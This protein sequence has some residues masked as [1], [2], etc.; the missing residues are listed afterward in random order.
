M[1][2]IVLLSDLKYDKVINLPLLKIEYIPSSIDLTQY[3][4][5]I[6]TSKNAIYSIDSF[7]QEWKNI[8]SYCIAPKTA[9][10]VEAYA[11]KIAF[12]GKSSHGNSFA[13]ELIPILTSKR[14]LY[15]CAQKTV[16]SLVEILQDNSVDIESL[17]TYKTACSEKYFEKPKPNSIII[18][19][20]PSTVECFFKR[21]NWDDTYKAVVIG[22]TTAKYLPENI[23][24][25]T[26]KNQSIDACIE[27][28][29][30]LQ[31]D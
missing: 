19:S 8:P 29:K 5:L 21:F 1:N 25:V 30:T 7:N 23:D 13:K 10:A 26:S 28:A 24:F 12:I 18:F 27:L 6:F 4:A 11:G 14:C 20:S 31:R 9:T 16:S 2:N 3:D 17:V 22:K 15:I